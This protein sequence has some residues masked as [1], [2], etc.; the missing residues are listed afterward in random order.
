MSWLKPVA[1]VNSEERVG[2]KSP[3]VMAVVGL[4]VLY[5]FGIAGRSGQTSFELTRKDDAI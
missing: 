5:F 1:G 2:F 4:I 3:I